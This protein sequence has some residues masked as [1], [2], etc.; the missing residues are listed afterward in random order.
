MKITISGT[1]VHRREIAGIDKLRGLP[2]TWYCFT[3]LEL[4]EPGYMPRQIDVIIVMEERILIIDLKDWRGKITSDA[5][6]WFQNGRSAD[7]SPVKKILE[8]ARKLATV[9]K[10]FLLKNLP[11][12]T[13]VDTPLVEG[14]VVVTGS[15]DI[16]GLTEFDRHRTFQIDDFCTFIQDPQQRKNV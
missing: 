14:C 4:I 3:N 13:R 1:G 11:R 16:R 7:T 12:G 2:S 5:E 8:N 6:R 10:A 9:L 15:C